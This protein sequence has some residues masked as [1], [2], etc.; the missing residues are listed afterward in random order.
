MAFLYGSRTE[1]PHVRM[2]RDV[3]DKSKLRLT[4]SETGSSPA[5]YGS[6]LASEL[7]AQVD[8]LPVTA[9]EVRPEARK[10]VTHVYGP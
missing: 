8:F 1:R 4:V 2:E 3:L 7:R 10:P 6:G 9:C 5:S